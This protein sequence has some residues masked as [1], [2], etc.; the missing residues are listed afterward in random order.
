MKP[1]QPEKDK[2][3]KDEVHH[4]NFGF[5]VQIISLE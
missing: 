1:M 2:Q 5:D 4:L 3:R